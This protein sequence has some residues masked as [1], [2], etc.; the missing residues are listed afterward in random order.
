MASGKLVSLDEF[1]DGRTYAGYGNAYKGYAPEL[2]I[3]EG[4]YRAFQPVQ[5]VRITIREKIEDHIREQPIVTTTYDSGIT[6]STP[7]PYVIPVERTRVPELTRVPEFT[8]DPVVDEAVKKNTTAILVLVL[9]V[10]VAGAV[11]T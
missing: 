6:I 4:S 3:E 7:E 10:I 5:P 9:L 11:L 1:D 2:L 8:T